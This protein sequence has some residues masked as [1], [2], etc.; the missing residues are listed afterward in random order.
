LIP[1]ILTVMLALLTNVLYCLRSII[2]ALVKEL[3]QG[4][5]MYY[6]I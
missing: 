4:L 5:Y 6:L 1:D 2:A 3:C